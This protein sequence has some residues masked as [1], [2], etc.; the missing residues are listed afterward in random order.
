MSNVVPMPMEHQPVAVEVEQAVLGALLLDG[1]LIPQVE[2]SGGSELFAD[3]LHQAIYCAALE[4]SNRGDAVLIERIARTPSL[5]PALEAV[6]GPGYV[7]KLTGA[8]TTPAMVANAVTYLAE[9]LARRRLFAAM[10]T[11]TRDLHEDL[12]AATVAARLETS[13]LAIG[14]EGQGRRPV[15]MLKATTEAIASIHAAWQ[16]EAP[17]MVR[18][19]LPPLDRLWA[20]A[21]PGELVILGGRP[22]MGKTAVALSMALHAAR[23]GHGVVIASLEMTPAAMA[24][25]ALS[26]DMA[27]DRTLVNYSRLREGDIDEAEMRATVESAKRVSNL[28]IQFLAREYSD[29][30]AMVAGVRQALRWLPRDRMPLIVVDYL[31]LM[32][33]QAR[34]RYEEVTKISIALK[35][36]AMSVKAPVL[37][38]SQLSRAVEQRDD[39]RPTLSDLRES[40]QLEQDADS[41][42]FCYRPEYYLERDQPDE[43]NLEESA[44]WHDAMA[45]VKNRVDIILAKQR[46]GMVGTARLG[47]NVATNHLWEV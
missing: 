30:G 12:D 7:I 28:P 39:K 3:M 22:S 21:G 34:N 35:S 4:T 33:A 15:S 20:G 26:E 1:G 36:L 16:G 29:A 14:V 37:A 10:A 9:L 18:S 44:D 19:G 6:G 38:L 13:L 32:E 2:A 45:R 24:L 23:E 40:G 31:Q 46:Q 5:Q 47:I 11:A 41:I 42:L 25:R 8:A 43:S 17:P 27:R